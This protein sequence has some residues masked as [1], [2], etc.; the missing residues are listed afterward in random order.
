MAS[1]L[2]EHSDRHI[3]WLF[4]TALHINDYNY[5]IQIQIF[6]TDY[7]DVF[8]SPLNYKHQSISL[9]FSLMTLLDLDDKTWY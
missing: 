5:N 4:S 2:I 3:M 9:F 6:G 7:N 8:T 1:M